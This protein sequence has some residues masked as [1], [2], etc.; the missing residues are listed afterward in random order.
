MTPMR[1]S[2]ESRKTHWLFSAFEQ[3][4]QQ[5]TKHGGVVTA[6]DNAE[7]RLRL[8]NL[9]NEL[10]GDLASEYGVDCNGNSKRPFLKWKTS[11]Q[12]FHWF[13]E[14][15]GIMQCGGFDVV[16]GN[17]P[18]VEYRDVKNAYTVRGYRTESCGNLYAFLWE[19]SIEI[20]ASFGRLGMIQPVAAVCTGGYE[21]LQT[22]LQS[23]GS[24]I[25][26]NFNDRPSKLFD[27]IEHIRLCIILH[28]L[29]ASR[30]THSTCYNKW[31][32]VERETLFNRLTFVDTSSLNAGG[33]MAK[34][35][36]PI[37]S[38]ILAKLHAVGG[39]ISEYEAN[40]NWSLF[41]T[42]KLSHFVQIL[43]F[44]PSIE[45]GSGVKREPS[46]LK[47]VSFVSAEHRD[48]FLAIL[49]SSMFY[50]MITVYSDCRNLNR[51][52]IEHA[53]FNFASPESA[54]D[55]VQLCEL[56]RQLMSD[57]LKNS[58]TL[59][60]RYK[61]YG[62]LQIQCTYPKHSKLIIDRV[63]GK[64]LRMTPAEIDFVTNFDIKYRMGQDDSESNE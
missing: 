47:R 36:S 26:S 4:R 12:P 39:H 34:V 14:F 21:P 59:T 51:R 48:V 56:S 24:S 45:D 55:V 20:T 38:S 9:N 54:R 35:G 52:E 61:K 13:V 25:V 33:A 44:V 46:E 62:E 49:N 57:I 18:Y 63:L 28:Q 23:S 1:R 43:D 60:M 42:R 22:I 27:G 5:Q 50:W 64:H 32:S 29:G 8:A 19:R 30:S 11:H 2:C 40:G 37:E 41:Y 31:Q 16:I 58:R 3:F 6:E 7:L 15:F 10:D 53:R 17:P